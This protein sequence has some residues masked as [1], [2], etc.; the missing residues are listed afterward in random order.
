MNHL[1][2]LQSASAATCRFGVVHCGRDRSCVQ[3]GLEALKAPRRRRHS[4]DLT[5]VANVERE[6]ARFFADVIVEARDR[7]NLDRTL[8]TLPRPLSVVCTGGITTTP[9][10]HPLF[11]QAWDESDWPV[12]TR[13]IRVGTDGGIVIVR[14]CLIQA[15]LSPPAPA[16]PV[17]ARRMTG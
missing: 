17:H 16:Q 10:F 11:Q 2:E 1:Q 15:E 8:K 4:P 14:G 9:S 12:S 5:R 13:P 3:N 6:Y 7:F